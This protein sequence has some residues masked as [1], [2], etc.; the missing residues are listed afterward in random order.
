MGVTKRAADRPAKSSSRRLAGPTRMEHTTPA[1]AQP[2]TF[3][4]R[5]GALDERGQA[6]VI[7]DDDADE[8]VAA[9]SGD[10][11]SVV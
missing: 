6:W 10:R 8:D 11:K 7:P 1:A 9:S 2:A 5:L 4:A 3:T